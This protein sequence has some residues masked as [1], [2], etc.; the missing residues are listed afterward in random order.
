MTMTEQPPEQPDH[1]FDP[2]S[3]WPHSLPVQQAV[4]RLLGQMTLAEKVELVTGD[5]NYQFG[6]Y[7]APIERLAIPPLHMADG[8][9]GIRINNGAVHE[10][11]ATALPAPILLGAT[12][13]PALAGRYGHVIGAEAR[14]SDHNV[15]LGP[16]V[17]I[18]R[19]PFGG[20]TFESFGEDPLLNARMAAPE[21]EAI[22][23]HAVLACLKHFVA[24]NQEEQRFNIDVQMDER[25]LREIYL[26]PF[27]M[28][29]RSTAVAS[30]MGA[31]NKVGGCHACENAPLL[32]G[33][34]RDEWGFRGWVMSD[35][36]ATHS[37]VAS[38]LAGLDQEQPQ[39]KFYG[40]VLQAAVESGEVPALTLDEMVRRILR[41]IVGLGL[42]DQPPEVGAMAVR[43]HGELA[44]EV[45]EQGVVLLKNDPAVLPL[46]TAGLRRVAVI[47]SDAD[48]VG[49]AGGGSGKVAPVHGVSLLEGILRR[50]GE[51]VEVSYAQ[52]TDVVTAAT[53]L[54][55]LAPVPS[56][57]LQPPGDDGS[58][59]LAQYWTNTDFEGQPLLER[60][61]PFVGLNL[62]F[63]NYPGFGAGS[64]K[65]P[66][67]PPELTGRISVRWRGRLRVPVSGRYTLGFTFLGRVRLLLDGACIIDDQ[68]HGK[69][70]AGT[71]TGTSGHSA[72]LAGRPATQVNLVATSVHP[73]PAQGPAAGAE[74]PL[75]LGS[76]GQGG[77]Q[78]GSTDAAVDLLAGR[79]YEL[80]IEYSADAPIQQHQVGAQIR[81]NWV[82]PAGVID[83]QI[84]AAAELAR[85]C[86][87]AI[88]AVRDFASEHMDR[89][90]LV[91]PNQQ[92]ELI[93]A[94]VAA[95]PNT[96]VVTMTGGPVETAS[97]EGDVPALLHAWYAGQEQGNALARLIFGDVNPSGK[98]PLSFPR[99]DSQTLHRGPEDYPGVDGV[100]RYSEGIFVGY[101]G[102]DRRQLQPQ[103]VFGHGLSYTTFEYS[104]LAVTLPGGV[105]TQGVVVHCRIRNTG[106]RAGAEVVQLY[107]GLPETMGAPPQQ[108]ADWAKVH[109][110][111]GASQQLSFRLEANSLER[112]FSCWDS[113]LRQ[114]R[115]AKGPVQVRVGASS[116][117]I[118]LTGSVEFG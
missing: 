101:R 81:F 93:R 45:A 31:F 53:L 6:F 106:T 69:A 115:V 74:Q 68:F 23:S 19:T 39:G 100:V 110:E 15:F 55:G 54:P 91:L 16:A 62:G 88:V 36:G 27:E 97:W 86:D 50:V 112:P 52:G 9:P 76:G 5:L 67:T 95:N 80:L 46:A 111:P 104:D 58:G 63:F 47:G 41:T 61:D 26:R 84:G 96:V 109:L 99:S 64:P 21:I 49:A 82:P 11:K 48:N 8:P 40:A 10:G 57:Y 90:S 70:A 24:N 59:L 94:V 114:W 102:Y 56:P 98:L 1:R 37:T 44:R 66:H 113:E 18:A 3:A 92:V 103:Y 17:D 32:T 29:V 75:L 22:Q 72:E 71:A 89:P 105:A 79:A 87:W 108:L 116:R 60:T 107:L 30:L 78:P 25:A 118:R 14:A 13:D 33:V 7:S 4:E 38:A 28:V 12:W 117:D 2:P 42:R 20:R 51:A 34:L 77:A 35:Y 73:I 85:Q 65:F 83:P 43:A